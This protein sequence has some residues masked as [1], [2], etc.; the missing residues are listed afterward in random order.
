M[1]EQSRIDEQFPHKYSVMLQDDYGGS[2][3]AL[4]TSNDWSEVIQFVNNYGEK[5][6]ADK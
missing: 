2:Y 6:N 1:D 5:T 4:L 3:D